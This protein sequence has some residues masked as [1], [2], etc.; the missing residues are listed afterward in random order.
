MTQHQDRPVWYEPHPVTQER[1]AAINAA[2]FVILDAVF[3]P[4]DHENPDVP[5]LKLDA[6]PAAQPVDPDAQTR[7]DVLKAALTEKGIKFRANATEAKLQE[8]LDAA[9]AA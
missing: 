7:I 4:E 5:E 9:P 8:L 1:K 6:A 3:A 2:G